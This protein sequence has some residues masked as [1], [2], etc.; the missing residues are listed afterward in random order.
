MT[1]M[2]SKTIM[3]KNNMAMNKKIYDW[4][5]YEIDPINKRRFN[6]LISML[7]SYLKAG[8]TVLDIGCG[9]AYLKTVLPPNI[10]Y[11]GVDNNEEAIAYANAR[12]AHIIK[13][14]IN[15][16]I[17]VEQNYD[18]IILSAI[19]EHLPE[20]EKL[21]KQV[22]DMLKAGGIV[23][24]NL[25]NEHTLWHRIKIMFGKGIDPNTLIGHGIH[26]HFPTIRQSIIFTSK[27]FEIID[28][29][30]FLSPGG[31]LE[32][33]LSKIPK[34]LLDFL[35]NHWPSLFASE[36]IFLCQKKEEQP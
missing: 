4:S 13:A 18:I 34:R 19:L 21:V 28:K 2:M 30:F 11:T 15:G 35:A 23:L 29:K 5:H 1:D 9:T 33:I 14:D 32:P 7:S 24:I 10:S 36:V 3:S 27:H 26:L 12:S 31:Q 16:I 8:T 17:P 25:P 6:L 20:P 22:K